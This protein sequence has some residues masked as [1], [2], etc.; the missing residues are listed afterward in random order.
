MRKSK[1]LKRQLIEAGGEYKKGNRKAA[2]EMWTKAAGARKV[3]TE[4]KRNKKSKAEEAEAQ[5][6]KSE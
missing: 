4:A 6:A 1:A 2:Y 3:L 5:K